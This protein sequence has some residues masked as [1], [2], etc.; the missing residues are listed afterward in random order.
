VRIPL[1]SQTVRLF[2]ARVLSCPA[3][4][5]IR[6]VVVTFDLF[7]ALV[8]MVAAVL[9]FVLVP[10]FRPIPNVVVTI[11]RFGLVR[12]GR[13]A[14]LLLVLAA[15]LLLVVGPSILPIREGG[16]AIEGLEH[17]LVLATF[18]VML[19]TPV[20]LRVG[21]IKGRVRIG[22]ITIERFLLRAVLASFAMVIAAPIHLAVGPCSSPMR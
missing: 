9:L 21:P 5:D 12:H 3:A 11:K 6:H 10:C 8:M 14:T 18:V 2:R 19:A 4:A 17:V 16:V 1:V 15:I 20:F 7:A 13:R 22:R